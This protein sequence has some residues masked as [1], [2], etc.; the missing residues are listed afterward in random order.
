MPPT[1][2][3]VFEALLRKL[4]RL[5]DGPASP[6]LRAA[7]GGAATRVVADVMS[8]TP[9]TCRPDDTLHRAAQIMWEADCGCVPVVDDGG[10]VVAMI[11][12]RDVCMA[13]YT[14]GL[15]LWQLPVGRS[16]SR[17]AVTIAADE[18]LDSALR[19]MQRHRVRRLPVLDADGRVI[20]V[21][22]LGDVARDATLA[23]DGRVAATLA[24]IVE[25][26]QRPAAAA[27]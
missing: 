5:A 17:N 9:R 16:A 4:R 25:P 13:A 20:G 7:A 8:A 26:D 14:Q 11:T 1:L 19:L 6:R 27:E 12:D 2:N 18:P 22:S 10:H 21:L 24:A 3:D 15:A 23:R